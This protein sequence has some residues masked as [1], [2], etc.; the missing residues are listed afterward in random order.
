MKRK[1]AFSCFVDAK[2]KFEREVMRWLWSLI[3]NLQIPPEDIYITCDPGVS[4]SLVSF[5]DTFDGLNVIYEAC[6]TEQ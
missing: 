5:L 1:V 6:F 2:P 3:E 4:S